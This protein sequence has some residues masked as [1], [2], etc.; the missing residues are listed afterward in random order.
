MIQPTLAL[1]FASS[2]RPAILYDAPSSAAGKMA[3]ISTDYPLERIVTTAG[4]VK[5]RDETGSLLWIEESA[6]G[7]RRTLKINVPIAQILE[8]PE[9]NAP[10]RFRAVQ[11]V[12]LEIRATESNGWVK[13]RH[14]S[15][16]EGYLHSR[17]AWG[18]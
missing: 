7:T 10:S 9:D 6:L 18:L 15:G 11:G 13:V 4:W 1:D 12:V 14:S 2:A 17:D 3:V 16:Q 8:K 5:V